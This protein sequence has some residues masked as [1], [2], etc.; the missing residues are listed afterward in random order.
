[1]KIILGSSSIF[2]KKIL[3]KAGIDF[4]VIPADIDEKSIRSENNEL[5]PLL[6]SYAKSQAVTNKVDSPSIIIACDQIVVCNSR[7][8]EKPT[9]NE[10]VKEWYDMYSKYPVNFINRI[11]VYNTMTKN[12]LS[13]LEISTASL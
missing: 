4:D 7:V 11:T 2:R 10:E 13:S 1:M 12:S 8:L 6:L 9:S 3:E 5:I